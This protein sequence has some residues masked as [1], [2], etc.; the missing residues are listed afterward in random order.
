MRT[1][2]T[3]QPIRLLSGMGPGDRPGPIKTAR[4]HLFVATVVAIAAIASLTACSSSSGGGSAGSSAASASTPAA[5]GDSGV[6]T[7]K[8]LLALARKGL[9]YGPTSG[10]VNPSSLHAA[11]AS[12]IDAFDYKP[13][14]NVKDV[15]LV[16]ASQNAPGLV[17]IGDTM[18][19]ILAKLNIGAHT[20]Y[21]DFT[22]AGAQ[23]AFNSALA[24]NPSVVVLITIT[25]ASVTS[26][27][28]AAKARQIP[29]ID[30]TASQA[31]D[32]G[33]LTAYVS[34]SFNL[35]QIL[36][37]AY[38]VAN[39]GPKANSVWLTLPTFPDVESP[40]GL[41][42]LK[43]ICPGCTTTE[44]TMTVAQDSS[45]VA[46][47]QLITSTVRANP[48]AQFITTPASCIP[49][50]AAHAALQQAGSKAVFGSG[51]CTPTG[52]GAVNAGVMPYIA[53]ASET[54][55][56][57]SVVDQLLRILSGQPPTVGT[58]PGAFLLDAQNTPT[59]STSP[60]FGPIDHWL[61]QSFDFVAP[62]SKAWGVDMSSIVADEK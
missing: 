23:T 32:G 53:T 28:A 15:A 48:S 60:T 52:L 17:H 31:T 20:F 7:A 25:P 27:I 51:G 58:G 43:E 36:Q 50:S 13:L 42:Y 10:N 2:P 14:S 11:T 12:D 54:W 56:A 44:Q 5:S 22:P 49:L 39:G 8:N 26:Q 3:P 46:F 55:N 21:G 33:D 18:T 4:R 24:S 1:R 37:A 30:G 34:E 19:A 59:T 9:I 35:V 41:A 62:Y 45:P 16:V 61:L 6:T 57:F 29:V 40:A 47:G 38:I